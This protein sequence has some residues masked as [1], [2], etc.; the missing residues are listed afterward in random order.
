MQLTYNSRI[1]VRLVLNSAGGID[2]ALLE[3][4]VFFVTVRCRIFCLFSNIIK[5][6]LAKIKF[7]KFGLKLFCISDAQ[8]LRCS[9]RFM[10]KKVLCEQLRI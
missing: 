3:L 7:K 8:L 9:E 10:P 1:E 6:S 5:V 2:V 4:W